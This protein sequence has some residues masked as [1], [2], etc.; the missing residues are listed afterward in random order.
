[1][2]PLKYPHGIAG[3]AV[4]ALG[5]LLALIGL[6]LAVGGGW[7]IG[8]GG[9]WYYLLA[10][11]GLVVSGLL[12]VAGR[13]VGAWLYIAVFV[14][15]AIWAFWESG[16]NGWALTPRLVGPFVLLVL[17]VL[18]LGK[19]S[20]VD[21]KRRVLGGLA[22][23]A[24]FAVVL[25]VA[26]YFG[27]GNQQ[28]APVPSAQEL[29][30]AGD[31]APEKTGA[32]WP[33]WG[34]T[35]S[36]QRFSPVTQINK[37][38]VGQ[39][40]QAWVYRSGDLSSKY[41]QETTPIKLGD[42]LYICSALN[43]IIA[44]DAATGSEIW[45]Y[46][47]GVKEDY[48]PYTA[49]CR[50]V[51]YYEVPQADPAQACA[52][53]IV[54]GTLDMRIIAVDAK[55][56]EPCRDFG[57]NGQVDLKLT[58]WGG[59]F[60]PGS[61]SITSVPV[62]VR[63]VIVTGHQVLDGQRRW[64]P[65]GAIHGIDAV[66]GQL[67]F[68]WDMMSPQT[69]TTPADG[70]HY[71]L[72][73]PNSWAPASGDEQLGLVYLPMGNSGA[74]Y[75][76]SLRRPAENEYST[77][78]V[79]LDVLT[80]KPRWHFQTVH[81]DVWDYDLGTQPTLVDIDTE[82]GRV[83]AVIMSSKQGEIFLLDRRDGTPIKPVESRDV[84]QGGVEPEQ[85]SATQPFSTYVTLRKPDLTERDM[86]G[87]SPIDQLYCRIQFH[88]A[89]YEGIYTPPST[90]RHWIQYPGYNGGSDWGGLAIDPTRNVV[91]ANY[92]DTPN[93]NRLIPRE[94]ADK[95]GLFPI[96]DP[97]RDNS[98][99]AEGPGP[100]EGVPYAI[101]VNAGWRVPFTGMLCK[102]PPYGGIR[103]FDLKTGETFWDKPFGTAEENGPFG[104][105]TKL[106]WSIGTPNNGGAV[107]TASGLIF[108]AATTDNYLRAIDINT[109][110]VV[111]K[112]RLPAGGQAN[113]MIYE[114]NGKAYL[115]IMAGGHHFMETPPGDYFVAFALPDAS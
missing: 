80:G 21:G 67:R 4:A 75:Y 41:G 90:D 60:I 97:R 33:I 50:G 110:D 103:A 100:Q 13:P 89:H 27:G 91:I 98:A 114:E 43:R 85:R 6:V 111:W 17:A 101:D 73:T 44:L 107:V 45:S 63:G 52:T 112:T 18:A 66:T 74:D 105:P 109:G 104:I 38:N 2:S 61:A 3:W 53:R 68:A 36:G 78:L 71:T 12:L 106:P 64:A 84:S 19:V 54:E 82:N 15:T 86:W 14:L 24:A 7:L 115:V 62:I 51:A 65:S 49:A 20:P 102:Q 10:G 95:M 87:M 58:L 35:R 77:A 48:V 16:L 56:G 93:Y 40:R 23:A 28:F 11:I 59:D 57:T 113:P 5:A 70:T 55:T 81:G 26:V 32:E 96:G 8:L 94:E 9:S 1:M 34:G 79:A 83:P 25:A 108:I 22:G 99:G 88:Q 76:S 29:A 46:D 37:D 72:G 39:L 31:P 30:A 69:T 42:R 47:P 92:N